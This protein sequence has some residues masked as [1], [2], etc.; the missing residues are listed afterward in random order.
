MD[1]F[2][3]QRVLRCQHPSSGAHFDPGA[4]CENGTCA[5]VNCN[6]PFGGFCADGACTCLN[7]YSGASCEAGSPFPSDGPVFMEHGCF[8]GSHDS[9]MSGS[10]YYKPTFYCRWLRRVM[11]LA[12]TPITW[13][14]VSSWSP[15]F[16]FLNSLQALLAMAIFSVGLPP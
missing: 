9:T 4:S 10:K 13:S 5:A 8:L 14:L 2:S 6:E 3:L 1:S 16:V 12:A 7:G 15:Q 11:S